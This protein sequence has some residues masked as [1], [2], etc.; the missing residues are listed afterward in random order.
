MTIKKHNVI[1]KLDQYA[2]INPIIINGEEITANLNG[3]IRV[4]MLEEIQNSLPGWELSVTYQNHGIALVIKQK[5]SQYQYH[6]FDAMYA[7]HEAIKKDFTMKP[8]FM[9]S[10]VDPAFHPNKRRGF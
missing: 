4:S 7:M 5:K 8:L 9:H 3:S 10:A 2:C 1:K 6:M